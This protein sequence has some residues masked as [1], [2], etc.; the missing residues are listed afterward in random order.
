MRYREAGMSEPA[1]RVEGH[2][3]DA[4]A[5]PEEALDELEEQ[6]YDVRRQT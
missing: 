4:A 5:H 1:H 2:S 6:G 3:T